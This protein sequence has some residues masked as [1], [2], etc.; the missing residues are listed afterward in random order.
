MWPA[1]ADDLCNI[2][3]RPIEI[4]HQRKITARLLNRIETGPLHVF[5][6]GEFQRLRIARLDDRNRYI[7]QTGALCRAPPS[8]AGN[9]L[10]V[11]AP[12]CAH[13][14][15]LNYPPLAN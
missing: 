12:Q 11:I 15:R 8:F 6:D 5:D 14:D 1:L 7:M 4:I 10:E 9:D 2:I 3:L 13:D